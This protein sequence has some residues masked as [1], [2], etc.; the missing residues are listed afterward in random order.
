MTLSL[1]T[2]GK[3]IFLLMSRYPLPL[4]QDRFSKLVSLGK[5]T[6]CMS[7]DRNGL[8]LRIRL[9]M[10]MR[11]SCG[12]FIFF[13]I[14]RDTKR[15]RRPLFIIIMHHSVILKGLKHMQTRNLWLRF[16]LSWVLVLVSVPRKYWTMYTWIAN[17]NGVNRNFWTSTYEYWISWTLFYE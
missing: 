16:I 13:P 7:K 5:K 14:M 8:E 1:K 15:I 11:H 6:T 17:F 10:A 12:R 2:N 3:K 9:D 4:R